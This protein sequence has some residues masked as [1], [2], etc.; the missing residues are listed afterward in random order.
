MSNQPTHHDLSSSDSDSESYDVSI[1]DDKEPVCR[2]PYM[3]K[4][5]AHT[6]FSS[7]KR[8]SDDLQG[9][10]YKGSMFLNNSNH[11]WFML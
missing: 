8:Q 7:K 10:E 11:H 3:R 2:R 4:G 5:R 1:T 9:K 6:S